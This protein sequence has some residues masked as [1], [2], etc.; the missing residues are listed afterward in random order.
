MM[1][2]IIYFSGGILIDDGWIRILGSGSEKLN[3]TISEWNKGKTYQKPGERPQYLLVAD[4]VVGGFFALNGGALGPELGKVYY[5]APD[6]LKWESLHI[7]YSE[8]IDFCLDGDMNQFY[9]KLRWST[10]QTDMSSITGSKSFFIYPYLWSVEG[11]D[12]NKDTRKVV[13]VEELYILEIDALK[14]LPTTAK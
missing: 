8:F 9:D 5:L 12:I 11:K 1:G 2:A 3:R 7:G 10:W 6:D 14:Q 13:P 4:D